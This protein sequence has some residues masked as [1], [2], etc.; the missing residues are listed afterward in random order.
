M[1]IISCRCRKVKTDESYKRKK[2]KNINSTNGIMINTKKLKNTKDPGMI[3]RSKAARHLQ[4]QLDPH[5]P[6]SAVAKVSRKLVHQMR[7]NY[8]LRFWLL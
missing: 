1:K 7:R 4:Q 8:F 3:H 6:Y 2:I 5:Y